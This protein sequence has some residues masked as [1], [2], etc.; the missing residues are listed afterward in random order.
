MSTFKYTPFDLD[1]PGIRLL[2][3]L[4]GEDPLIECDLFQA[5]RDGDDIDSIPYEALSYTWGGNEKAAS[6]QIGSQI[7]NVTENLYLALQHLRYRDEDRILWVDAICIDQNNLRERGHQVNQMRNIYSQAE[8]VLIWLGS[9]TDDTDILLDSL[10]QLEERSRRDWSIKDKRWF[11]TWSSLQLEMQSEHWDL[12]YRQME[13]LNSLLERPWFKRMWILQE[14]ANAS[15]ATVCSGTKSVS[16]RVFAITPLLLEVH[17]EPHCQAVLDIMPGWSRE[18]SWWSAKRD[19]RTL[20]FKFRASEAG[21][22]RDKI[23]ALLGMSSDCQDGCG[24]LADYTKNLSQVVHDAT[25]FLFLV[26]DG[27]YTIASLVDSIFID[28]IRS[29]KTMVKIEGQMWVSEIL[30]SRYRAPV[31]TDVITSAAGNVHSGHEIMSYLLR[32]GGANVKITSNVLKAAEENEEVKEILEVLWK[33][34]GDEVL[35]IA[36]GPGHERALFRLLEQPEIKIRLTDDVVYA[37]AGHPAEGCKVLCA[38]LEQSGRVEIKDGAF[39]VAK[40]VMQKLARLLDTGMITI[41][42]TGT[43]ISNIR[44]SRHVRPGWQPPRYSHHALQW[45]SFFHDQPFDPEWRPQFDQGWE[46][47]FNEMD[48]HTRLEETRKSIVHRT[49]DLTLMLDAKE[50][51]VMYKG[52]KKVLDLFR[53]HLYKANNI[54]G[55]TVPIHVH[56]RVSWHE[57]IRSA[58]WRRRGDV[59]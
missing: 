1:R 31:S 16:A 15:R 21:D 52:W 44:P 7:Q 29:L 42:T 46:E 30:K 41:T 5:W 18:S 3:L 2:R 9:A 48:D 8:R 26:N 53:S 20:L 17:P 13:G 34:R 27:S 58:L 22:A 47:W 28:T 59:M 10:K 4:K 43:L 24:L 11:E 40:Y 37:A 23:Y 35:V 50:L 55:T 39:D 36:A 45:A 38:L 32:Q 49:Q 25:V 14:V 19:L 57:K 56:G 12:A 6:V 33:E 51:E 54:C